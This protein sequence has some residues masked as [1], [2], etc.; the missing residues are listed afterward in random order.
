[1]RHADPL[2]DGPVGEADL[3]AGRP[4]PGRGPSVGEAASDGEAL[5][6]GER[7]AAAARRS[8][9]LGCGPGSLEFPDERLPLRDAGDHVA[10]A[11]LAGL[12]PQGLVDQ[13]VGPGRLVRNQLVGEMTAQALLVDTGVDLDDGV[14]PLAEVLVGQADDDRRADAGVALERRFDLSRV[15]VLAA[16]HDEVGAPVGDV[17]VAVVVEP[18]EVADRRP[19]VPGPGVAA[20]DPGP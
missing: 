7:V 14:D 20:D 11:D 3:L 6:Q 19:A 5:G 2:P 12:V 18:A 17:E 1:M 4:A 10:L 16:C 13:V 9:E 8:D 15:D